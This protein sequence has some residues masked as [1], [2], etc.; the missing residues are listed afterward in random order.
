[1]AGSFGPPAAALAAAPASGFLSAG[2]L[3][4][5]SAFDAF[6]AAFDA[7]V[8]AAAMSL[9]NAGLP[10]ASTTRHSEGS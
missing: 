9:A 6:D 10:V 2:D 3:A 5:A 4:E 1:M 8:A 7:A